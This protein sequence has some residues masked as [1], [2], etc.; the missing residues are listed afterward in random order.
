[1]YKGHHMM[2]G[3]HYIKWASNAKDGG[4]TYKTS[5]YNGGG[6]N[7]KRG[8]TSKFKEPPNME[9]PPSK[10]GGAL[11]FIKWER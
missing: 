5:P 9:E 3:L 2:K 8:P 6:A 10:N 7:L 4:A 11:V 1:M